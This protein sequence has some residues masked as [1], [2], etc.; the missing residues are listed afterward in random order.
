[1]MDS[2]RGILANLGKFLMLHPY[3]GI[4]AAHRG[5]NLHWIL[6]EKSLPPTEAITYIG[7]LRR[8]PFRKGKIH[9]GE[10][11]IIRIHARPK[12]YSNGGP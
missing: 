11:L 1:M 6:M 7:S 5:N 2:H 8:I 10:I 4:L 12:T 3:G 9:D